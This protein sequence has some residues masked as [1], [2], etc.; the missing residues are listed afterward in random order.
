VRRTIE[1]APGCG[2]E[3]L[4]L[5]AFSSDNWKRPANEVSALMGLLRTYLAAEV[6]EC[7]LRSVRISVIGRRDRLAAST[8][9]AIEAAEHA[10]RNGRRLHVRIA[11]DYSS[12]DALLSAAEACA[13][14]G[15]WT[16][17]EFGRHLDSRDVDLLIRTSGEQRLS[18]FLLWESAYAEFIFTERLW[19]DFTGEDLASAVAEF[20]RR[21]R[22]FGEVPAA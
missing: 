7:V 14:S 3:T 22:K 16:R 19:P 21:V 12:R 20:R 4:T 5:Y 13:A 6:D 18:D 2:I 8:L 9:E 10:T 11:V 1:A 15:A 17:E